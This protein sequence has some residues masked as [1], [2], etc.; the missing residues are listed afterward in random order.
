MRLASALSVQHAFDFPDRPNFATVSGEVFR[1]RRFLQR[2]SHDFR[3]EKSAREPSGLTNTV[4]ISPE[5]IEAEWKS[6]VETLIEELGQL[7]AGWDL[8]V[9]S[10]IDGEIIRNAKDLV[11]R[12]AAPG[13]PPPSVVPTVNGT[14][15]LEWHTIRYDAEVEILGPAQYQLFTMVVGTP[16]WEGTVEQDEAVDRLQRLVAE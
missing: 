11:A 8:G 16:A 4:A 6:T 5:N 10:P 14:V 12:L 7:Q 2:T 9:A 1:P 15:Q 13:T 3:E